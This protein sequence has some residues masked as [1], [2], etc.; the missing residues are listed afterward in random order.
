M[1]R[2]NG[3]NA[4]LRRPPPLSAA[5]EKETQADSC[6]AHRPRNTPCDVSLDEF[7]AAVRESC[8]APAA[9]CMIVSYS[10]RSLCQTGDGH[11][12][13]LAAFAPASRMVLLLDVARFKYPPHWVPLEA[14]YEALRPPD[15]VTGKPRGFLMVSAGGP[16]SAFL[17]LSRR[18]TC[19][20]PEIE[21]WM[22]FLS[23]PGGALRRALTPP[24]DGGSKD[25]LASAVRRVLA[26][27]NAL[28]DLGMAVE[29]YV[30]HCSCAGEARQRVLDG[31]HA[32]ALHAALLDAAVEESRA[33]VLTLLLM[34]AHADALACADAGVREALRAWEEEDSP[35]AAEVAHIRTQL[36]ALRSE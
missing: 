33:D 27:T 35:L 19:C 4:V 34:A 21:A 9:S 6:C 30:P 36:E 8:F 10:R 11:F 25:T 2:C 28:P 26:A 14:L 23:S 16:P 7:E 3:A 5:E 17:T 32:C 12:S 1:A 13:P 29:L 24:D 15:S 22:A 31:L 18:R 20:T